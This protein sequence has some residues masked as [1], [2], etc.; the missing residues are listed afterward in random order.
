MHTRPALAAHVCARS[1]S[2][3]RHSTRTIISQALLV[4][5]SG[6]MLPGPLRIGNLGPDNQKEWPTTMAGSGTVELGV[7]GAT[8]IMFVQWGPKGSIPRRGGERG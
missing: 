7:G 3:S 1:S 8:S 5:C 2:P 4:T 6:R